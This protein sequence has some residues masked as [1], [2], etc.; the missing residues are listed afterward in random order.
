[1][2]GIPARPSTAAMAHDLSEFPASQDPDLALRIVPPMRDLG[3]GFQVRRA[4]PAAQRRMVGPFVFFDQMGPVTLVGEQAL[5]VRP[6]PHIGLATVTYLFAGKILHRDSLG[7]VQRIEPGAVNWM[8]AGRGIVHSERTPPEL[9][10]TGSRLFGIQT[11]LGLP[12][13]HEEAEPTFIH[14]PEDALPTIEVDGAALKLIAGTSHGMRSPVPT[15]SPTLYA[16]LSLPADTRFVVPAEHE[17]R[18]A[19][20]VDGTVTLPG[21]TVCGAGEMLV[22]RPGGEV[23]LHASAAPA[24]LLLL[25]GAPLEGPRYI[26]WNFVSSSIARI[27]KAK[28]D[29]RAGR[30]GRVPDETEFIPLPERLPGPVNYP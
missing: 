1:M 21:G 14:F 2:R 9:R 12:L 23:T 15:M 6:H 13:E 29:W 17:E 27:E 5:D 18:G 26:W 25:G 16:D 10:G 11:W 8:T 4:L 19:Y 3:G 20:I 28:E 30:F 22:F 24:R 7:T